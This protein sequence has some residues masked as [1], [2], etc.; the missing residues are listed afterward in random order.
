MRPEK[1]FMH[2]TKDLFGLLRACDTEKL[3]KTQCNEVA[4]IGIFTA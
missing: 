3:G 1:I 2:Q 4:L